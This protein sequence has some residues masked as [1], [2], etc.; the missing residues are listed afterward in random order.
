M[1]RKALWKSTYITTT[2]DTKNLSSYWASSYGAF[3]GKIFEVNGPWVETDLSWA[4]LRDIFHFADVP[5]PSQ[6]QKWVTDTMSSDERYEM[7]VEADQ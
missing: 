4:H 6:E 1:G 7:E 2:N 3:P 5:F